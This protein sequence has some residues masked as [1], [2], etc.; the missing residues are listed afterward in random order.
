MPAPDVAEILKLENS[1]WD[2]LVTGDGQADAALLD[3]TF[4]G[5]YETGFSDKAGHVGQLSDGPTVLRFSISE[6]RLLVPGDDLAILC[7]RAEFIRVGASEPEAMYVSS[8]WQRT[9]RVWRNIFSQ[10]TAVGNRAPV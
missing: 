10:D 3:D 2:A 9:A 4:L 5:V 8:I 6:V 1:V 7:Y